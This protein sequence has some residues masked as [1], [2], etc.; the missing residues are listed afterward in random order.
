MLQFDAVAAGTRII[1]LSAWPLN[2]IPPFLSAAAR[3][4]TQ[5]SAHGTGGAS[6]V[7]VCVRLP[8]T[9]LLLQVD[10]EYVGYKEQFPGKGQHVRCATLS[11]SG[12]TTSTL[13]LLL[14]VSMTLRRPDSTSNRDCKT[15]NSRFHGI[16]AEC[17]VNGEAEGK[18]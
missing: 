16:V 9:L 2:R 10:V 3:G 11:C 18:V 4:Q 5:G 12:V 6:N 8:L 14:L 13:P 1:M 7:V 15:P 17:G